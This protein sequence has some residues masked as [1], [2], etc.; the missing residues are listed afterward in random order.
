MNLELSFA[1]LTFGGKKKERV[2]RTMQRLMKAGV[3]T[4]KSLEQLYKIYS[5]NGTK[6][7]NTTALALKEWQKKNSSG[8]PLSECMAGWISPAEQMIIAGGE[9][10][11]NLA[12][13][14]TD[15]LMATA[16]ASKIR[17]TLILGIIYPV[18]M[19]FAII[20]ALYGFS[21]SIVP[22]FATIVE[23]AKWTGNAGRIYAVSE[24]I[25]GPA[26]YFGIALL[27][28]IGALIATLPYITG[29]VRPYLDQAFPWSLY[30]I[31]MGAS[32][33]IAL[34]GSLSAGIPI[35]DALTNISKTSQ[36]YLKTRTD[37]I[38]SG[39]DMGKNLGSA[40]E[41]TRHNFP[42]PDINGEIAVYSDLPGFE[43]NLDTLAKEWIE[44]SIA[45][46]QI[47]SKVMGNA[48]LLILALCVGFMAIS[49]FELQDIILKETQG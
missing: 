5:K 17:N 13:S 37:A 45:R 25:T 49:V 32:F 10:G 16:A 34:R 24:F 29:A 3:S 35:T 12:D 20:F 46:A 22:T 18:V 6:K 11:E 31:I 26:K 23:P 19:T 15:A 47:T 42:D 40:M 21:T 41:R 2:L 4:T 38:K 28:A 8:K 43:D 7:K 14:F 1:R 9:K 39:L 33:M 36:P 48:M 27:A 30:K 44:N